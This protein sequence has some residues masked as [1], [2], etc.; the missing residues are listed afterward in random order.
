MTEIKKTYY[1]TG[2]LCQEYFEEDGK[3]EG[4]YKSYY[5]SG[6]IQEIVP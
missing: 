6:N 4:I 3:K 1:V 5:Q 2:E